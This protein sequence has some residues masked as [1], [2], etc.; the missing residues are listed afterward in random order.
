MVINIYD[1]QVIVS[2]VNYL[3]AV[4]ATTLTVTISAIFD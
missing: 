4:I 1:A 2:V 3:Q